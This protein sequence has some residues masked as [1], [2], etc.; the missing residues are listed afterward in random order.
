MRTDA[1][2]LDYGNDI[3]IRCQQDAATPGAVMV[4]VGGILDLIDEY[5]R[6]DTDFQRI[7]PCGGTESVPANKK[8][9]DTGK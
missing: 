7:R 2:P 8:T 1:A 6:K 5:I 4:F 9:V 3:M